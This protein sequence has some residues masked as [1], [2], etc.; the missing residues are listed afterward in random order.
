MTQPKYLT[1]GDIKKLEEALDT[2][3]LETMIAV[4]DRI[5]ER[6]LAI[7]PKVL[8]LDSKIGNSDW[9]KKRG[10]PARPSTKKK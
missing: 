7:A 6:H 10:V 8:N 4:A 2:A 3:D 1:G 9:L 5:L